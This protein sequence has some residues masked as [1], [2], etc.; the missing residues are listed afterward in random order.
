VNS[1]NQDQAISTNYFK[2]KILKEEVESKCWLC[3]QREETT[4]HL[5][6]GC[7]VVVKN[8]YLMKRDKVGA[9]LHYSICKAVGIE[10]ADKWYTHIRTHTHTHTHTHTNQY[11]NMK[12]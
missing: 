1:L 8:E 6:P 9:H 12:M 5:T 10:T 11:V 2:N 4:D 3:K 7:P